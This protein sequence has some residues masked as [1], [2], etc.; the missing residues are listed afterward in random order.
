[1]TKKNKKFTAKIVG[2]ISE[3]IATE[4][5]ISEFANVEIVQS[6]KLD[7]H[8][9]KHASEFFSIDSY[10]KTLMNI[11]EIINNPYYI[12]YDEKKQSLKYYGKIEQYVCV[13]VKL[14]KK[15]PFVSTIYPQGKAKIDK[16]KAL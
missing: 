1:M 10:Y 3:E 8:T 11:N 5:N 16:L 7:I 2:Q 4:N 15:G 13:V 12:E 9:N 14:D 6:T